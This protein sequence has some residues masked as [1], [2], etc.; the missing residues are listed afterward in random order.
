MWN[1]PAGEE[2]VGFLRVRCECVEWKCLE[3]KQVEYECT[4]CVLNLT[5]KD[6]SVQGQ[7]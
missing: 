2:R 1:L 6:R 4:D 7:L 3:Y 5:V